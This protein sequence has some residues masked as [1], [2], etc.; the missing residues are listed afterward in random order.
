MK[1]IV[2]FGL[3]LLLGSFGTIV[4]CSGADSKDYSLKK[5]IEL[6]QKKWE[7]VARRS[8]SSSRTQRDFHTDIAKKIVKHKVLIGLNLTELSLLFGD[9]STL[10][11]QSKILHGCNYYYMFNYDA[12]L[13]C[14][15]TN[16]EEKVI[17]AIILNS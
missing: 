2:P 8:G 15:S 4:A 5:F 14:I 7:L 16:D 12:Q 3:M 11:S 9:Y 6:D 10:D 13:I 1:K 17:E